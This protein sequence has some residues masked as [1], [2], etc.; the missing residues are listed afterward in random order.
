[1]SIHEC[2]CYAY[3]VEEVEISWDESAWRPI[4]ETEWRDHEPQCGLEEGSE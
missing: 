1:M 4:G 2:G 3:K